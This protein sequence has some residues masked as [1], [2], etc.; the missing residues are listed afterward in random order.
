MELLVTHRKPIIFVVPRGSGKSLYII[1]L[2]VDDVNMPAR[3]TCGAQPPVELLRQWLDHWNWYDM[4][5]CYMINLVDIQLMCA[6]RPPGAPSWRAHSKRTVPF[7]S[8]LE[9]SPVA[10]GAKDNDTSHASKPDFPMK[11]FQLNCCA[12]SEGFS[13][14]PNCSSAR[15]GY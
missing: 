13:F 15:P 5:D 10:L 1:V 3:G 12:S 11:S 6:M 2:F 14:S 9:Q 4:K 8:P 7:C